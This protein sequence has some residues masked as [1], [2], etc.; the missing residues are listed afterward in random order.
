MSFKIEERTEAIASVLLPDPLISC[1][2]GPGHNAVP[3]CF[4]IFPFAI[5][6]I[7][8]FVEDESPQPIALVICFF[9]WYMCTN[10]NVYLCVYACLCTLPPFPPTLYL[11]KPPCKYCHHPIDTPPG[12]LACYLPDP[13]HTT[14]YD[15]SLDC[16]PPVPL[17]A[18]CQE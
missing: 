16:R 3:I 10:E 12:H 2:E 6:F 17:L 1:A 9:V 5:V 11:S 13:Q 7:P 8:C 4:A 15:M 14:N 18:Q